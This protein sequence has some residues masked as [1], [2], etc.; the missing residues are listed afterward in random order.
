MNRILSLCMLLL[1]APALGEIVE[2]KVDF[3]NE[4]GSAVLYYDDAIEAPSPGVVVV[5]EW[6]GMDDYTRSRAKQLAEAGYS[7]VAVDMY[8]HGKVAQHPGDAK[9]FMNA[10]LENP[11]SMNARFDAALS[12]LGSAPNV[13]P[14]RRY[15]I[16]YCF[17]GAVVLNQARRGADLAGVASF[18]GSLGTDKPAAPGVIKARILVATGADDPMV[19]ARQVG[20]FVVEMSD[21]GAELQL[22]SFPGVVHGFTNPAATAK[23]EEFDMPLAYDERADAISWQAL[24]Q[25]LAR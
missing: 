11:E 10:A 19:P 9:A 18:H 6:W 15:A 7:A 13:D 3:N 12:L 16:G 1:A 4:L 17:G 14:A 24:M 8:G 20:D 22:L 23:G 2:K 25:M 21:A 5:H